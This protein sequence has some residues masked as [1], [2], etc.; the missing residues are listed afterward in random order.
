M[1]VYTYTTLDEPNA[2]T[3]TQAFGINN[4]GQIVGGYDFAH[5]FL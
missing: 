4:A 2:T 5:G 1:P 3:I